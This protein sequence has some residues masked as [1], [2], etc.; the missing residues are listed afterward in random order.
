R[1]SSTLSMRTRATSETSPL[2]LHDALPICKNRPLR[3]YRVTI[4]T[5]QH[6]NVPDKP[7]PNRHRGWE[8]AAVSVAQ[9]EPG[10]GPT[11]RRI[12]LGDRKSTRLNSSHVKISYAVLCLKKKMN[13]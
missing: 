9:P 12:L 1:A 2:S 10:S 3:R 4:G 5:V 6:G 8:A 13:T 7:V 11:V